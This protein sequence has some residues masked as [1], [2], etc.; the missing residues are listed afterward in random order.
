MK[1]H[2][3]KQQMNIPI[4]L[5]MASILLSSGL[6]AQAK[7]RTSC[8][9][10]APAPCNE[11]ACCR[12]YC[13]GPEMEAINAPVNPITCNGDWV[14]S[15]AG[16]YWNFHQDRMEFAIDNGVTEDD[17]ES[18]R[19]FID[20]EYE[21]PKT[22]W[23]FGFK[24]GI[25]FN[26]TCDGWDFG[27]EWTR[28]NGNSH[29]HVD[30]EPDEN[31]ILLALWSYVNGT[32]GASTFADVTDI[33][34]EWNVN[35]NLIDGSLGRAFW[36]SK[37]LSLRPFI[38]FRFASIKQ[39]Y[40]LLHKGGQFNENFTPDVNNEVDIDNDFRGFG[41][42][43]G[44][45]SVWNLGCGWGIYGEASLS[46]VYGRF[47]IDHDEQNR[48]SETPFTKAKVLEIE[49]SFRAVR[50]M[51]DFGIG[52]TWAS[53][54]CDCQYGFRASLGWETHLFFKQNQMNRIVHDTDEIYITPTPGNLDTQGWTLRLDWSF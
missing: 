15:I 8:A 22:S 27:L 53:L 4:T 2:G 51:A 18:N 35:L 9:P 45:D 32:G 40:H 50:Y 41:F 17:W 5:A 16:F 7:E 23:D 13:L 11:A 37:R 28:F 36:N 46:L 19:L 20:A 52:V 48:Q 10:S 25:G 54:F 30:I 47:S 33:I 12:T 26:T 1:H 42:R 3:R 39:N 49:R 21:M 24:V 43:G 38:G 31:R 29:T 14:V 44:L 6:S 34:A